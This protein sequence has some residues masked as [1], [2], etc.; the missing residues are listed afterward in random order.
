MIPKDKIDARLKHLTD[1][2]ERTQKTN[3]NTPRSVSGNRVDTTLYSELRSSTYS[4]LQSVF[5]PSH[6]YTQELSTIDGYASAVQTRRI[7]GVLQA[8]RMEFDSGWLDGL[9]G[10]VRA[11]VFG[12]FMDMATHLL[13]EGYKDAAAVIAGSTLEGH[14]RSLTI[15]HGLSTTQAK[16]GKDEPLKADMLNAALSK[17]SAYGTT[18]QKSVTGWLGLRNDAA[19]GHYTKYTHEE[20]AVMCAG[21]AVFIAQT[22]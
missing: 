5:G 11:E 7:A 16:H 2:A 21:I 17:A 12:D 10:L 18:Q 3:F 14:L 8:V 22:R 20:V 9:Q 15:T 6:A 1:L 4:F 19:H 13:S